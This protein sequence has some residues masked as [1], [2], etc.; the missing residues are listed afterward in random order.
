MKTVKTTSEHPDFIALVSQ[1]DAYLSVRNGEDDV[2]FKQFNKID[3]I[4]NVILV[5][6]TEGVAVGCGAFKKYDEQ[7]VEIK[8]MFTLPTQRGRGIA[9]LVLSN[10]ENWAAGLGFAFALLETRKDM[11]DAV[12]LYKRYG[13]EIIPNYD[14]YAAVETSICMKKCLNTE[15][16]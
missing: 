3:V 2:F 8:R 1:L 4:K 12:N 11:V 5:F 13:Y 6:N 15:G 16:V 9:K 7:T 14:Q 10:L